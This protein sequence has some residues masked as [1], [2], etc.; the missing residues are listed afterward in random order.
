M[1]K[2]VNHLIPASFIQPPN[3]GSMGKIFSEARTWLAARNLY[4]SIPLPPS[5][6]YLSESLEFQG[7]S[8]DNG[9]YPQYGGARV[10]WQFTLSLGPGF[11]KIRASDSNF[12]LYILDVPI[13]YS[14][15]FTNPTSLDSMQQHPTNFSR[16]QVVEGQEKQNTIFKKHGKLSSWT[17]CDQGRRCGT[18]L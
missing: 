14:V 17:M 3:L 1:V 2:V 9:I 18:T 15:L 6:F 5:S 4:C 10:P 7:I 8:S 16:K 11:A 12:K 13:F